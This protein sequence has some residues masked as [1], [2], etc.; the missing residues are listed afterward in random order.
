MSGPKAGLRIPDADAVEMARE[1]AGKGRG[2]EDPLRPRR[3]RARRE[4]APLLLELE[5]FEPTLFFLEKPGSEES[6][7]RILMP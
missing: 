7:A 3:H 5:L 4:G 1:R 6:L 2:S